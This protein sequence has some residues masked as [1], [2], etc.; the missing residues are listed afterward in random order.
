MARENVRLDW[1]QAALSTSF[2]RDW[3]IKLF[4]EDAVASLPVLKAG[5]NKGQPKGFVHWRKAASAGYCH[6]CQS[7]VAVGL[8]RPWFLLTAQ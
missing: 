7:P 8:D 4:G 6:E 2:G 1:K 5:K 3:A